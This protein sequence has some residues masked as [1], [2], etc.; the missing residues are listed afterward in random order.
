VKIGIPNITTGQKLWITLQKL[1]GQQK[2]AMDVVRPT[3][4]WKL[5]IYNVVNSNKFEYFI[6]FIIL[7]NLLIFML[8]FHR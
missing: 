5:K 3:V 8:K 1:A 6:L 2:P 4:P 7:A